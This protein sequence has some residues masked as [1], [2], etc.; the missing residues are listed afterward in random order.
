[1]RAG[2]RC[3]LVRVTK[4]AR[5]SRRRGNMQASRAAGTRVTNRRSFLNGMTL[6]GAAAL[7]P[8]PTHATASSVRLAQASQAAG[9]GSPAPA[10]T[11][12]SVG[13]LAGSSNGYAYAIK[14]GP[15]IFLNRS[16]E[17]TSEL[18]SRFGI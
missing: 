2:S 9:A 1:M 13:R 15:W 16:E 4:A 18:Q 17:H 14:A 3:P 5:H 11:V 8:S 6:A 7:T 12:K 10:L